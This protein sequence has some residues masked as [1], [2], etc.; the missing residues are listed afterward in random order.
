LER[1]GFLVYCDKC[2]EKLS[3]N[4]WKALNQGIKVYKI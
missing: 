2:A 3:L 1:E 4:K